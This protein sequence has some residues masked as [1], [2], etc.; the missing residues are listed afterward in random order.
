MP[1]LSSPDGLFVVPSEPLLYLYLI[2]VFLLVFLV[3]ALS[4]GQVR[5]LFLADS[6]PPVQ[7]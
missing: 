2:W 6:E 5:R 7:A 3:A 1:R 4:R